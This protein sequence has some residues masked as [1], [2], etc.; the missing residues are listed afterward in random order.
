MNFQTINAELDNEK[1]RKRFRHGIYKEI[2]RKYI[3]RN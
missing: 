1:K 2:R 3:Y